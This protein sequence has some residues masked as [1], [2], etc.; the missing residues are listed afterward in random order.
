MLYHVKYLAVFLMLIED[1]LGKQ[2]LRDGLA[3][4][5]W[6]LR[7]NSLHPHDLMLGPL[8]SIFC[9]GLVINVSDLFQFDGIVVALFRGD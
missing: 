9:R 6:S 8:H 3:A 1:R 5:R 2:V 7:S 4:L